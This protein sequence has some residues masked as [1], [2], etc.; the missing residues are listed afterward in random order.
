[1]NKSQLVIAMVEMVT[2][3]PSI[4]SDDTIIDTVLDKKWYCSECG[5][6]SGLTTS[7]GGCPSCGRSAEMK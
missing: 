4:T 6:T 5:Q 1:M 3:M 2:D 7:S